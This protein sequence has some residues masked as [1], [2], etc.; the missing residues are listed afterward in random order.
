[1]AST[2]IL[3]TNFGSIISGDMNGLRTSEVRNP[4]H[5]VLTL[6][7]CNNAHRICYRDTRR[8]IAQTCAG[9]TNTGPCMSRTSYWRSSKSCASSATWS[10]MIGIFTRCA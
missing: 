4:F 6:D 5:C 2:G 7:L 3:I 10:K 8:G 9:C 1:M